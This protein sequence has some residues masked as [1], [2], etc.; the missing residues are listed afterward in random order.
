MA[1]KKES[2]GLEDKENT[3]ALLETNYMSVTL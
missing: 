2:P 3:V 1:F